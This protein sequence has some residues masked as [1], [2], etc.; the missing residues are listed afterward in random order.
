MDAEDRANPAPSGLAAAD[1]QRVHRALR[2]LSAVNRAMQ[3]AA[4]EDELLEEMCG[5][6]VNT[7]GYR[8]AWV[9]YAEQDAKKS[10]RPVAN[11]GFEGGFLADVQVTWDEADERGRGAA[12][13]AI[14][15]G[16][17]HV[18]RNI[19]TDP[20]FTPWREAATRRG[21]A[22]VIGLPL[23]IENE[24]LGALMIYAPEPDAFDAPEVELLSELA[25]DLCYGISSLR[26]RIKQREAE[27]AVRRMAYYDSG[28]GLPNRALLRER[29]ERAI[30]GAKQRNRPFPLLLL[31]IDRFREVND[32]LGYGEGDRLLQQMGPRLKKILPQ[33]DTIAYLGEDEFA[34]LLAA[35]DAEAALQAA[36]AIMTALNEPFEL[37]GFQVDVRASI[38]ISLFPGHGSDPDALILRADDAMHRAKSANAGFLVY[39]GGPGREHTRRL[40]LIGDLIRAIDSDQLLLYCQPKVDIRSGRIC[41]A[42]ALVRWR[43]PKHGMVSLYELIPLAEQTGLIKPLTHWMLGAALRQCHEW[44]ENGLEVPLAVNVSMRNL[45]DPA[46][47]ERING[48]LLTWGTQPGQLQIELTESALMEDPAGTLEVLNRLHGMGIELFV[49]DF[50]TGYSS[51]SYLQ[52]LPIDTIKIDQSFVKDMTTNEDSANIVRSTIELA[53]NLELKVVAEGVESRELFERLAALGCDVAQG[54]YIDQPF[55]AEQLKDWHARSPW[56]GNAAGG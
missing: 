4:R 37:S 12:G 20:N 17:P 23:R 52:K 1:M 55:P 7:G 11:A 53:H 25:D 31:D 28:T 8:L 46:F 39:S 29:V 54:Y 38:G 34:V 26:S 2:T 18:I 22:S 40:A 27:E 5:I 21:F 51:L 16:Q 43:H 10:V 32:A 50:G 49:D 48:L 9:G 35:G 42:E 19:L 47:L 3:R 24:M 44:Y 33:A 30:A 45:R 14:R 6:I 41:G 36:R 56:G 13:S 15:S